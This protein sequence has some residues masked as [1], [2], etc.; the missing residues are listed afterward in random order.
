VHSKV[1]RALDDLASDYESFSQDL[2]SCQA[3]VQA[4]TSDSCMTGASQAIV[5]AQRT[6][7]VTDS[8]ILGMG[9]PN[10][11]VVASLVFDEAS[12]NVRSAFRAIADAGAKATVGQV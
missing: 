5:S 3:A 7:R 8:R 1:H 10:Q 2:A 11:K 6:S 9:A 4:S 12:L